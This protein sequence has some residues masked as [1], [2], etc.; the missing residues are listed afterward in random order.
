MKKSTMALVLIT[1]CGIT[2]FSAFQQAIGADLTISHSPLTAIASGPSG[3]DSSLLEVEPFCCPS[4]AVEVSATQVVGE[5]DFQWILIG[6]NVP[7]NTPKGK[8][9]IKD[10]EI[11]GVEV[12]YSIATSSPGSTYISQTRLTE[13]TTPDAA[14]VMMDDATDRTAVGPTCYTSS[15]DFV[16]D[17]TITLAL[18]MVFGSASDK[19]RIGGIKLIMGVH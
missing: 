16:P 12:C 10:L 11:R 19:I 17:G 2:C 18:K 5:N 8:K 3:P 4:T 14:F 13:M 7:E 6:L 1:V 15:T 9:N